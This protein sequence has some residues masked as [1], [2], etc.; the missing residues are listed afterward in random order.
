[1]SLV[2]HFTYSL[3]FLNKYFIKQLTLVLLLSIIGVFL[4]SSL[5][6]QT[7][8]TWAS[9]GLSTLPAPGNVHQLEHSLPPPAQGVDSISVQTNVRLTGGTTYIYLYGRSSRNA[10]LGY[11]ESARITAT[12]DTTVTLQIDGVAT[13]DMEAIIVGVY[14]YGAGTATV[15]PPITKR[16]TVAAKTPTPLVAGYLAEFFDLV[17]DKAL[18]RDVLDWEVLQADAYALSANADSIAE[19]HDVL[20]FTLRRIDRHSYLQPPTE[21]RGWATGN[22]DEDAV[23]PNLKYATGRRVDKHM[24]YLQMPGV[25]SGHDK[26]VRAYADSLTRLIVRLDQPETSEWV[27][28]L[29]SNT[30]GNCWAMLAGIGPL[31]GDGLCG[32]FMQRDGSDANGWWYWEGASWLGRRQIQTLDKLYTLRQPARIAVIYGPKTSSSGEVVAIAFRGLP[33]SRSFGQPTS[34]YSTGNRTLYLSDGAAVLLTVTVYGDRNKVPYGTEIVP[35]EIVVPVRGVD[36]PSEAAATWL[37][38]GRR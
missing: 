1:M 23:D 26:T 11:Q 8:A 5:L 17:R 25:S 18:D 28:D 34:G 20:D 31:L 37:R 27:L 16:R 4:S 30:G 12:G 2:K 29:R 22:N 3:F 14:H 38:R 24:V 21:H 36:A 9:A 7:P 10:Y 35:D 15:A 6:A 19:I 13:T 33:N 32:Y